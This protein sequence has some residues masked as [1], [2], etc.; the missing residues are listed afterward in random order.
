MSY[1]NECLYAVGRKEGRNFV[2]GSV[3][4]VEININRSTNCIPAV[5]SYPVRGRLFS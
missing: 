2:C 1:R 4:F 5:S 3:F